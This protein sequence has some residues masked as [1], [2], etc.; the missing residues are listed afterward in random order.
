[1]TDME[2]TTTDAKVAAYEASS[3]VFGGLMR[4]MRELSQKKPEATLSK[5][6]VAILNRILADIRAVLRDEP[7]AKYLD[8]LDDDE[9]PQN[10]DAVLVMVQY[11]TALAAYHK[12]YYMYVRLLG[13]HRWLTAAT[14]EEI[15][16]YG[17][18]E[19]C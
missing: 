9:L 16:Q 1:M 6:K 15:R 17:R 7:E 13:D 11:Q 12:R 4:E 10:S 14:V 3:D 8:P 5:G 19:D 18:F 2:D